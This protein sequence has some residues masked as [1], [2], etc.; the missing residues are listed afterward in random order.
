[1]TLRRTVIIVAVLNFV[2][3]IVEFVSGR[4]FDSV[5]LLGD[6]IDFLEDAAVNILILLALGWSLTARVRVSYLFAGLLLLPGI[7]FLWVGID[8]ISEPTVPDS[9]GMSLVGLGA[10]AVNVSCA[11]LVARHRTE[12]GGLVQAAFLVAR[13]DAI[14]NL[15]II[16]AGIVTLFLLSPVPDLIVG[17]VIFVMNL[18]AALT[19][20]KAARRELPH[21]T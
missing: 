17:L 13:N 19:V 18:D 15:L 20:V 1:M 16:T 12:E 14:A 6:S 3:F 10:L 9:L 8:K 2:F 11:V 4:V 21:Q 5:A 7:T